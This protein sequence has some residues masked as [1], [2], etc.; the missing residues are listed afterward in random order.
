[1]RRKVLDGWMDKVKRKG[2]SN[3]MEKGETKK[4]ID[5]EKGQKQRAGEVM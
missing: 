2:E 1:M 5:G 3:E 4:W